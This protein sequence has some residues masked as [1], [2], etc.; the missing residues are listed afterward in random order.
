VLRHAKY[1]YDWLKPAF[2]SRYITFGRVNASE[3]R[4]TSGCSRFSSPISHS[5]NANGFV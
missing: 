4:I 1:V 2:A 5:Q 3:R